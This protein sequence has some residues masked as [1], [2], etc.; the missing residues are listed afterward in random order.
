ML[1]LSH[2]CT[3]RLGKGVSPGRS[4]TGSAPEIQFRRRIRFA[5]DN[6]EASSLS[7]HPAG[8]GSCRRAAKPL[9]QHTSSR[10]HTTSPGNG[11]LGI[12]R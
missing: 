1:Q 11:I 6:I 3:H 8:V 9:N 7:R 10:W 4:I 12:D 2:S 5:E